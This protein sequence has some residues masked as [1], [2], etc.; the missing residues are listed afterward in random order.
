MII[1]FWFVTFIVIDGLNSLIG[2]QTGIKMGWLIE[3][4]L[5]S[6]IATALSKAWKK[7]REAQKE[8]KY[9]QDLA[10]SGLSEYE[11]ILSRL[12]EGKRSYCMDNVGNS[13]LLEKYV[14]QL[15]GSNDLDQRQADILLNGLLGRT[16]EEPYKSV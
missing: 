11:Y 12:P 6:L 8:E 7:R 2:I 15:V 5:V 3:I 10:A 4:V 14:Q 16:A 9:A 1:V 13:L